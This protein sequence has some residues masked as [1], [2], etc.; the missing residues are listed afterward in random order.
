[1][2][3]LNSHVA[4]LQHEFIG[5]DEDSSCGLRNTSVRRCS[6]LMEGT[7]HLPRPP[8]YESLA[9]RFLQASTIWAIVSFRLMEIS[10]PG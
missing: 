9:V 7:T 3:C 6:R 1:M 4:K 2:K 10:H 8:D 5:V